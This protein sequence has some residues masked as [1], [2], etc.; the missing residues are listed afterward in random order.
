MCSEFVIRLLLEV[1]RTNNA[2]V[3]TL[4]RL[5]NDSESLSTLQ[6][7]PAI[8]RRTAMVANTVA[9]V[10]GGLVVTEGFAFK[11]KEMHKPNTCLIYGKWYQHIVRYWL[12]VDI[13]GYNHIIWKRFAGYAL[14]YCGI[15]E[16]VCTLVWG[17]EEPKIPIPPLQLSS[18]PSSILEGYSMSVGVVPITLVNEMVP[19]RTQGSD[20]NTNS[21]YRA[22]L[23]VSSYLL[24]NT[25]QRLV[26]TSDLT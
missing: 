16:N 12:L 5:S 15:M 23:L 10:L 21:A 7:D 3:A 4:Q 20:H 24:S 18:V 26:C 2:S 17:E 22:Y 19:E 1:V 13:K 8:A 14:L 25:S 6:L 9:Q 11:M